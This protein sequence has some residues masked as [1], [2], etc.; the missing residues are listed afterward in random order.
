ME[1]KLAY[2]VSIISIIVNFLLTI[3]KLL[4]GI[5][6]SSQA[7]ISDAIH[8]AS[9]VFSTLIV[10]IGVHISNKKSDK[11]HPYGHEKFESLAAILLAVT[12]ALIGIKI[13]INGFNTII[14]K[15]YKEMP[16]FIALIAAIVSIG[17]KEWMYRYTKKV[18]VK[19]NSDVLLADAW[20]HRSDSLSSIGA[21]VGIL[22]SILGLKFFDPLASIIIAVFILKVAYDILTD[23]I[24]KIMDSACSEEVENSIRELVLKNKQVLSIDDLKTRLF[25]SKMYVDIEIGL[26]SNMSLIKAH[27]IAHEIHDQV[28]KEF[29]N[30]KHCM[31]HVN[32]KEK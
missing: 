27:K 28:E 7:M 29:S 19:I 15:T 5:F 20:H 4:A 31:V 21:F 13:G 17:A 11:K 6:G 25:G 23:S 1:K 3:C 22:G 32:P 18:A 26:D 14:N 24:D 12:L 2:K 16:T 9:D 30:C 8:S 10:I